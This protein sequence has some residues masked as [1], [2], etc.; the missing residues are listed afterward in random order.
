MSEPLE[1]S[2]ARDERL[3]A[4]LHSYLQAVDAGKAPDR[5]ALLREHPELAAELEAFFADQDRIEQAVRGMR[6]AEPST[7]EGAG[8]HAEYPTLP[9]DGQ[10]AP[11]SGT[12]VRY[13][14]D[15][16][17]LE[18][19]ARGGM[20]VVYKAR[21]VSLNRIVALKMILAGQLASPEDVHRFRR[22]AE[23]AANLDHPNIVPIY[24]VGEHEG[25]HYFSM[26]FIEGG[27]LSA[28]LAR[29]AS[30]G[31]NAAD[32]K[33][34]ALALRAGDKAGQRRIAGLMTQVARAVHHAHQRGILHRDL[35]PG[36]ILIDTQ[37][38]PHVSDFGLAKRIE[39]D[40]R[41]TRSGAIVGT[42]S[43][44]APEQARSEK[45][46]TTG[47][48]VYSLGAVLYEMLTRRPPFRAETP[49]DT[50]LQVLEREPDRPRS[51]N[52]HIDRDLETISL[53][54]LDK[55][56]KPR[57]GSAEALAEE[58][59]R[60]LN[61][62]PIVARPAGAFERGWRW[63]R[64]NPVVAGLTTAAALLLF[65]GTGISSYFAVR[66]QA[67]RRISQR[68]LYIAEMRLAQHAWEQNQPDRVLE[69]L[70]G[71]LPEH[72]G[73]EDLRGFE[74]Y[75]WQRRC[76]FYSLTLKG[77]SGAL[78]VVT[79]VA[80]SPDGKRIVS[81][82]V[83]KTLK[84][85]DA[86][87]G[88]ETLTLKGHSSSVL[89]VA[90]SPDGKRIVSGS[91]DKTLK[92]WDAATGRETL[93]IKGHST[94][95][96][97][98]AFSPDGK[99]IASCSVDFTLKV[100]DAATGKETLTIKGV[101]SVAFSPDGK[102]I[103]SGTFNGVPKVWDAT[104]GKETL[105]IKGHGSGGVVSLVAVSPDGKRIAS[106]PDVDWT[107]KVWDA[108]TG[109]ET[110]TLEGHTQSVRC[111]AFS[112]DGKRIASGSD[113][114]TLKVWD[115]ATG[116]ETLTI[117]GHTNGITSVAFSPDGKRLVS[118]SKFELKVW[119]TA[120]GP[121]AVTLKGHSREVSSVAFSPDGKR[122]V[123]GSWDST[124]VWD[125]ATGRETLT[126]KGGTSVAFSP[127]GKR[128]VSGGFGMPKLWDASTGQQTLALEGYG[129]VSSVAFS[130]DGTRIVGTNVTH[131]V[132]G[133]L[134]ETLKVWDASTGKET[135][136][137]WRQSASVLSVAFSP[138]GK[139]IVSGNLDHTLKVWVAN[140]HRRETLTLKGHSAHVSSVA[141]SP[142]GKRIVSGSADN[143]LKVWDAATGKE[144]LTLRGHRHYVTSVAFSPDGK[145]LV[146]GSYD[147]TLKV[148]DAAT[149]QETL[150][151]K[152]HGGP[153]LSVAFSPDGQRIVSGSAD[154]TLKVWD[155][156][157]EA[158]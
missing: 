137:L 45:V 23:A 158:E 122:V 31:S 84:V 17:L 73:G 125:A 77:H 98:V 64:R 101:T 3:H 34:P 41:Q 88:R 53:K 60:W 19:I 142:D 65:V 114:K 83:D 132:K 79:S 99:R 119:D 71:Q 24:E 21:Q 106:I 30:E 133:R 22:E 127:D 129:D 151:L 54:C 1:D 52:G 113:D 26:K 25:Q 46:L 35:K 33:N 97:R 13:F 144:T 5:Q 100:W 157:F 49:L 20:G 10:A 124:K 2:A 139:R 50:V 147:N 143:T 6:P 136:S 14:G 118:S 4:I 9:P 75:Y 12:K 55:D 67:E 51:I 69:L 103:V 146:S 156:T 94:G 130:P 68:R 85:W 145:R 40:A 78:G 108:A 135:L 150:T 44:M 117:K 28:T 134:D 110:Q 126:I 153:V 63:C 8:P 131:V 47:V 27:S 80:F 62:E 70:D 138:D 87:T 140:T 95:I 59:E 18:E 149:G 109:Q 29:S 102:R 91:D 155:A 81:G 120:T 39:G 141:F 66:A 96:T 32:R 115:V 148:W 111:L 121:E 42:P 112:P 57:Y 74:W 58:L 116:R 36:N 154:R 56:P 152:G 90:F 7:L 93:T 37:G 43:Y 61:G 16:E 107:L 123:S 38:Q 11:P 128:I 76:H 86:A 104:T 105:T 92:V 15:Y 48:D 89:C 72:T 82:S